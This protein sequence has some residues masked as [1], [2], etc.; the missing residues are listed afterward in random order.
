M[1]V[2]DFFTA[3]KTLQIFNIELKAKVKAHQNAEEIIFWK[4]IN[5]KTIALVSETA[6]YHW[7]IEGESAPT[8]MF[9]RH[10]S[11]AGSQ[12]INYR[13]DAECKWLVL[14]GIAAKENRV[15]GSMQLYSTERR[16]SQPIEGHAASFVRFKM[17][18]N[19][20][21]SNLFCFSVKNEAGGKL[22]VIEVGSPPAGNQPFPKKAV[23]VPYTAETANDFPVSM[24]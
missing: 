7:S 6:V 14:V 17:D 22:H 4:W 10:Q 2:V 8:K 9:E 13:A 5:E 21:P 15:V 23:D 20:H 19:P 3:G 24:Q 16:V 11:L 18:G 1:I 12:I